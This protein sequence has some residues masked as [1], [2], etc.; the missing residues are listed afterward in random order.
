[1]SKLSNP[2]STG[3]GGGHFEAQVQASFVAL[4]LTGGYAPSLPCWPI[5]EIKLQGKIDE[6]DTDDLIV[7]V[8]SADSKERRKLIGQ[9]KH[10]ISITKRDAVFGDVIQSAWNDFNNPAIF[11]KNKDIIALITGPL[12]GTDAKNVPWILRQARHTKNVDEFFRNVNQANFSPSKSIEKL[13][14]I[15]HH[16]KDANGGAEVNSEEL[17]SFLRHFHLLGYDLGGEAGVMIS[18]LHSHISQFHP[19]YSHWLWPRLIDVVQT[20]NQDAG[21]ITRENLPEDIVDAFKQKVTSEIPERL[22]TSQ[23]D[24]K[25]AWTQHPDAS[26]IALTILVGSWNDKQE[27][28]MRTLAALL[29]IDYDEWIQKAREILHQPGSPLS[30]KNG[31]WTV[32]RRPELWRQLGSRVLDQ[33]LYA[34]KELAISILKE[35]DPA[36]ELPSDERYAA[37]VHGKTPSFSPAIRQGIAEGLAILGTLPEYCSNCSQGNAETTA[38]LAIR[39]IF[40][41]AEWR[42]WGSL[43]RVLPILAEAAPKE[44]LDAVEVA[45]RLSPCP[46]DELFSQEGNGITGS[47]YLTGLLWA[48]EGLAWDEKNI[49][50]AC[51]LLA[52]L[53]NHDPGGQWANR[54]ESSLTNILLPWMP[55]TLASVDKRKVTVQTVIKEWPDIGWN[56]LLSL[57]PKQHQTTTGTHKPQW[58]EVIPDDWEKGVTKHEYWLQTSSY[59]ELAVSTVRQDVAKL[60][61]LIERFD[62]LP[63]PAFDQLLEKLSSEPIKALPEEKRQTLWCQLK[64]FTRKHRRHADAKWALPDQLLSPV[65]AIAEKLAPIDPFLLYK[66]LFSGRDFDLYEVSGSWKEQRIKLEE[67]RAS[68]VKE[69]ARQHG[70]DGVIRFAESIKSPRDVG[71]GLAAISTPEIEK[72]LVPNFLDSENEKHSGLVNS[73]IWRRHHDEGWNWCDGIIKTEWSYRETGKFLA[74]LPFTRNTWERAYH[75]LDKHQDEYWTQTGALP[76]EVEEGLSFAIDK[77]LEFGRPHAAINCLAMML[78]SNIQIDSTQ[79]VRVLLGALKSSEP[80]YALDS[81]HITEIIRKLHSDSGASEDDIFRV[82]WAYLPLLNQLNGEKPVFLHKKLANDPDFFCE[83]I[84]LIYRSRKKEDKDEALSEEK[85]SI[86]ANAYNLL[87]EWSRP[88]GLRD[89]GTLDSR[90]FGLWLKRVRE[91]CLVT[92]HLEVALIK[93]GEALIHT[94]ADEN[95]L[96]INKTVAEELNDRHSEEIRNGFRTSLY[97]S[98]GVHTVDPSGKPEMDLSDKY[99]KMAEDAEN[100]GFHRLAST[101][102]ALSENYIREAE[103]VRSE[104]GEDQYE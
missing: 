54:P 94:P 62:N 43:N 98:R 31:I 77:L 46:F 75:W 92:G 25:T 85:K 10:A 57:L 53:A 38:F 16:L 84:Q 64:K 55:H 14:S 81:Y 101:L 72:K 30:L 89:D 18:L 23:E 95:G 1:M 41:G 91:T 15:K 102:R 13:E 47:N 36:F 39:E 48:L 67:R 8:Q 26:Y 44:F 59:A 96:W 6:Y 29:G 69:I 90:R 104:F 76:Y 3:G 17:Y 78:H 66:E 33:N 74:C 99:G 65:E 35:P 52:E 60:S 32:L 71:V 87:S 11:S 70:V 5:I 80:S 2:F 42:L 19:Q 58:K 100:A 45:L 20:W 12:N 63:K 68:A 34:F 82:E 22:K 27:H 103:R 24:H 28:D 21:T 88:P 73:F 49:V 37:R 79:C 7:Y 56:L 97:N 61:D 51:D 9:V 50:S 93:I 4:M 83:V 40:D 86:A